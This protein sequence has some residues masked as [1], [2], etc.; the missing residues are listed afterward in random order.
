MVMHTSK[1]VSCASKVT[2]H[3]PTDAVMLDGA[4]F[5]IVAYTSISEV[6]VILESLK[7]SVPP[8]AVSDFAGS[9]F[10]EYPKRAFARFSAVMLF[11]PFSPSNSI[12][13]DDPIVDAAV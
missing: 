7:V 8:A 13:S 12:F 5:G 10:S 6:V 9:L 3:F 11:V 1:A 2:T 4:M